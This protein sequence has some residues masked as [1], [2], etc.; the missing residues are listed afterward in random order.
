MRLTLSGCR[1]G[2]L[3]RWYERAVGSISDL[4][5]MH[6]LFIIVS[7]YYQLCLNQSVMSITEVISPTRLP[8]QR[9]SARAFLV[10]PRALRSQT[11]RRTYGSEHLPVAVGRKS[12]LR[13][14]KPI[15]HGTPV[16]RYI[17]A[18][19]PVFDCVCHILT[20]TIVVALYQRL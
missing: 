15:M 7:L 13:L 11:I 3:N 10:H 8:N 2:V 19:D 14:C 4:C 20:V 9:K 18:A 16:R 12:A 17:S 5:K 1:H 6:H